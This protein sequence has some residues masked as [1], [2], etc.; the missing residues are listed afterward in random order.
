MTGYKSTFT[1]LRRHATRGVRSRVEDDLDHSLLFLLEMLVCLRRGGEW[2]MVCGEA[3]D[4]ERIAVGQQRQ[5][6]VDP[7]LDVGLTLSNLNLLVEQLE[8]WERDRPRRRR[9]R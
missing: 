6:L 8:R 2:K 7:G 1:G 5:D 4:P 3:I 9:R